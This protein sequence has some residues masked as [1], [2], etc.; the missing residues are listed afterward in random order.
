MAKE[1]YVYI[2]SGR[3]DI[4]YTGVTNNI[5][6]RVAE[7]K[8][9]LCEFTGRYHLDRLVYFESTDDI[10]SALAREKQLKPWRREKKIRLIRTI[11]PLFLDLSAEWP[12]LEAGALAGSRLSR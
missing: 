5:F 8:A 1:Y 10:W 3:C 12:P 6:R 4:F 7:H 2:M 11:N 9:G